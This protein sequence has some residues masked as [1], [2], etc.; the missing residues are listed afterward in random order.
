M[1]NIVEPALESCTGEDLDKP[2]SQETFLV[3][4]KKV[5]ERVAQHLKEQP[6]IVAHSESTFDGSG[7]RRLF[8]NK[9]ELD[10]VN[11]YYFFSEFS[12]FELLAS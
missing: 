8:T 7:I 6:V 2:I 3:E 10:K 5:A 9:F 12:S 1:S 11:Y 4:F